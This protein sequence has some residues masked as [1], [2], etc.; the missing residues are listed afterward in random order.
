[1]NDNLQKHDIAEAL[2][3]LQAGNAEQADKLLRTVLA[4]DREN[5]DALYL[6]GMVSLQ[7]QRWVEAAELID[8]ALSI[9]PKRV[10]YHGNLGEAR[11]ALGRFDEATASFQ[12]L[13]S[14][15]PDNALAHFNLGRTYALRGQPGD[16]ISQLEQAVAARPDFLEARRALASLLLESGQAAAA[17]SQNEEIIQQA[18]GDVEAVANC[19]AALTAAG[20]AEDAVEL[21]TK[22]RTEHSN[23][24][25]VLGNLG[26]ALAVADRSHDAVSMLQEALGVEPKNPRLLNNLGNLLRRLRRFEEAERHLR[27]ALEL[28]S[29]YAEA[30]NNLA[31]VYFDQNQYADAEAEIMQALELAPT[32]AHVVN[33]LGL[34]QQYTNRMNEAAESFRRALELDPAYLEAQTNLATVYSGIGRIDEAIDIFDSVL[35]RNPTRLTARWNRC[36]ALLLS[37]DYGRGWDDYERR[38]EIDD[39]VP[40][41]FAQ[42]HWV[43]EDLRD[44]SITVYGEQGP[45]DV[46]MFAHCL[47]DLTGQAKHVSLQVD[48]RLVALMGRCFPACTVDSEKAAHGGWTPAETDFVVPFGS[49]PGHFR[50]SEEDFEC[51]Q[52]RYLTTDS[53]AVEHWRA[54]YAALG[55]GP[56]IGISW[57]GGANALERSRRVMNLTDWS[58]LLGDPRLTVVNL[59]HGDCAE[60]LA[61]FKAAHGIAVHSWVD[62][63]IDLDDYAAQIDA[64]DLVVSV[65]NTTVHFAGALG[66]Q[67]WVVAPAQPSWRWQIDR[68]D[69]PWYRSALIFRQQQDQMWRHVLD[70]IGDELGRWIRERGDI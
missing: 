23:N 53:K 42:P 12:A 69:S 40:R 64:L 57:R 54:R 10:K 31:L 25:L 33:N 8:R 14:E 21:L 35:A 19:G 68:D 37:G 11:L 36:N 34:V 5:V 51:V 7:N 44:Q 29:D 26:L 52:G 20:R 39:E 45:G 63:G 65:A 38:W 18:P 9:D 30:R 32:V 62:T 50:R 22:A 56:A 27:D 58:S 4:Q 3:L 6:L 43:D 67:V 48:D 59:Q 17:V 49:L 16:A 70:G 13:L 1:M 2:K 66:K 24:S 55:D 60:E 28:R 46:V 41:T 61:T 47:G 15:E